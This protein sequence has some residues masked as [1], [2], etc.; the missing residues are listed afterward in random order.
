MAIKLFLMSSLFQENF[1][2]VGGSIKALIEKSAGL[3]KI[4]AG[5]PLGE[6]ISDKK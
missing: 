6:N 2:F 4:R 3:L 5:Q 1:S